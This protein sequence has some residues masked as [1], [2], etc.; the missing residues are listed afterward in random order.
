ME[1]EFIKEKDKLILCYSPEFGPEDVRKKLEANEEV[2]IKK[3]FF[4]RKELICE[5]DEEQ[6]D[7]S[8]TLRFCVGT[9]GEKYTLLDK[10]VFRTDH[11][12]SFSN[13]IRLN[14]RLFVAYYQISILK[15]IDRLIDGDFFVV[16]NEETENG[17]TYE[18]YQKL[19]ASFPNTTE[20]KKYADKRISVILEDYFPTCE[21]F[22]KVYEKYIDKKTVK[23]FRKREEDVPELN[24]QIELAQFIEIE[25]ELRQM[26]DAA[27]GYSENAWQIRIQKILQLL[28]P[29]Y[30]LGAREIS[31][32][33][34]DEYDKRPDFVLVDTNG[35][36]DI[37]EIKKPEIQIITKQA[38]YRNNYVP[39]KAFAGAVQQIEKYIYCLTTG[40]GREK[41][42]DELKKHLPDGVSPRV[43]NPRGI[44][45]LG[46]SK[47]F[48]PQQ[49]DDFE[50][51]K[52]QYKHI[53]DIMTYDD[54]LDRIRNIISSLRLRLKIE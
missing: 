45:I 50:L 51:I 53:A 11:Q 49:I 12:F 42:V 38:S 16:G 39:V 22:Q 30:I 5:Y 48:N 19:I 37:L 31:F 35:F 29:Q 33:G 23:L 15:R 10:R 46:R 13:D 34:M 8:E 24:L 14:Q 6:Y 9:V 26:L 17:M 36:V 28:Y 1:I 43:V 20:L 44:L 21:R 32:P 41:V 40:S 27:S 2:A 7:A 47:G 18:E 54:F 25:A 52:R 3:T 4:V